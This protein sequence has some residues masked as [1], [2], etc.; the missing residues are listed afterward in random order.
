MDDLNL[1]YPIESEENSFDNTTDRLFWFNHISDLHVYP[2]S[3]STK[4]FEQFLET[5]E[6]ISPNF[7]IVSGDI[8]TGYLG[9]S[10]VTSVG[11]EREAEWA[12]YRELLEEY[13]PQSEEHWFDVRG[14]HDSLSV[15]SKQS[16]GNLFYNYSPQSERLN[17]L[18][19]PSV[20]YKMV[21]KTYGKYLFI[22]CDFNMYPF[23]SL[24]FAHFAI[25]STES[26]DELEDILD[27]YA[28]QVNHT[29]LVNHY[30]FS[31]L[32]SHYRTTVSK[33][34]FSNLMHDYR[35]LVHLTG[36]L[37]QKNMYSILTGPKDG[38]IELEIADLKV[39]K[40]FR[41]CAFDNDLFSFHDFSL[42]EIENRPL[43]L[44][45]NP[46]DSRFL[47][48]ISPINRIAQSK[49]LRVLIFDGH[50]PQDQR[51]VKVLAYFDRDI[52]AKSNPT[53]LSKTSNADHPLWVG[54]WDNKQ[55]NDGSKHKILVEVTLKNGKAYE[56]DVQSF[57]LNGKQAFM[58]INVA[59]L[60]QRTNIL[61]FF[62]SVF[63]LELI[64]FFVC[65][66]VLPKLLKWKYFPPA[67]FQKMSLQLKKSL[68]DLKSLNFL[69][70]VRLHFI[71]NFW[72]YSK[73]PQKIWRVLLIS[74]LLLLVTPLAI[75][76]LT[77]TSWG[78]IFIWISVING[79]SQ[80]YV[81]SFIMGSMFLGLVY[82]PIINTISK[83]VIIKKKFPKKFANP[84]LLYK[85]STWLAL[86]TTAYSLFNFFW[87]TLPYN[88]YG[89]LLSFALIWNTF[90]LLVL[91]IYI[92]IRNLVHLFANTKTKLKM[93]SDEEFEDNNTLL[94]DVTD[95]FKKN[96]R[97][98]KKYT[99]HSNSTSDSDSVSVSNSNSNS[100][101]D[102]N[103]NLNSYTDSINFQKNN[104][105]DSSYTESN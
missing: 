12:L 85:P 26:L 29:I 46:L 66:I 51:A 49:Y 47:T 91:L 9:K 2:G 76:P 93:P 3:D 5:I 14:N 88:Y 83:T 48:N 16:K 90:L 105:S 31:Y 62:V 99:K 87:R 103:P 78:V 100:D 59:Q 22:N 45:T 19:R 80:F 54:G 67:R 34:T 7:T 96:S 79:K 64:I 68:I 74:G 44:I 61:I 15:N 55:F 70:L 40:M 77:N 89:A 72:K 38:V 104:Q 23:P 56:N 52:K 1:P 42:A 81:L 4:N 30:P 86:I 37:H 8:T 28:N 63:F 69:Q 20:Y 92:V 97:K 18:N 6:R 65:L 10:Q 33:R 43:V 102:S 101:L 57:S 13:V 75:G 94:S 82:F 98:N 73:I 36:H 17:E 21:T 50:L 53:V 58:G 11:F 41:V 95:I 25:P 35:I 71:Y 84:N 24:P 39:H 27:K 32:N 60:Y